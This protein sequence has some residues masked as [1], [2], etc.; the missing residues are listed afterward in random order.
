MAAGIGDNASTTFIDDAGHAAPF[1]APEAFVRILE[2][3]LTPN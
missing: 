1:E 3:F 2:E